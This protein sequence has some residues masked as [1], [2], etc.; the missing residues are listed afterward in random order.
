[1]TVL[2]RTSMYLG[3]DDLE[4]IQKL[5]KLWKEKYGFNFSKADIVRYC[6]KQM[7]ENVKSK[8]N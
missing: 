4:R 5:K 3:D 6:I 2:H 1:M 7:Y 8:E